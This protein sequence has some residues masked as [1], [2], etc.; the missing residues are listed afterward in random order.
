MLISKPKIVLEDFEQAKFDI[1]KLEN[2]KV[3][4]I[5]SVA[6]AAKQINKEGARKV[7]LKEEKPRK[8]YSYS[9]QSLSEQTRLNTMHAVSL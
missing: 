2:N 9:E 5:F 7:I 1:L 6:E 4:I 8:D 3:D